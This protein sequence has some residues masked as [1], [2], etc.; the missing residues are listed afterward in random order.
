LE[1]NRILFPEHPVTEH[2]FRNPAAHPWIL[3]LVA[4]LAVLTDQISKMLVESRMVLGQSIPVMGGFFR[5]TFIKNAGGAFGI[6]FG[7]GWFYL[8]ASIVAA[9]MI[10]FYLRRLPAEQIL[11]RFSLAL[12]LGG[13][14]GN[15]VD[16][17]RVG[18]VTDFLDFGI[19]R[20]R[21]PVFNLADA[22]VTVGV[23]LFFLSMIPTRKESSDHTAQTDRS[24]PG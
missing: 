17:L 5:L 4:I 3:W 16:R 7:G 1:G 18:V 2:S 12:I 10:F 11:P 8:A 20:L 22:F 19:G 13:A 21:W 23:V 9:A 24:H 14:L 6:F 15:L